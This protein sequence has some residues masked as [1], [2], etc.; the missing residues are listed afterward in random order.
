MKSKK[1]KRKVKVDDRLFSRDDDTAANENISDTTLQK[2]SAD[3]YERRTKMWTNFTRGDFWIAIGLY[4][5][6]ASAAFVVL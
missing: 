4:L 3:F 6:L 5:I 1:F 2:A